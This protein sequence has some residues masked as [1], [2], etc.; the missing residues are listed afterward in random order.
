MLY[1]Y[2]TKPSDSHIM[3]LG[4]VLIK[5]R[6]KENTLGDQREHFNRTLTHVIAS[7]ATTFQIKYIPGMQQPREK[8]VS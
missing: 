1:L 8:S 4:F 3:K 7:P 2:S 6:G 5:N